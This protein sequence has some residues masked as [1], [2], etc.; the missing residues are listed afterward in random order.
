MN[1]FTSWKQVILREICDDISYG[2]TASASNDIVGPKFLRITD[3]VPELI[4]WDSVPHCE[5]EPQKSDKYLLKAGDIVIARTGATTGYAKRINK[6]VDAVF[7][8]YLVRI[9]VKPEHDNRFV[10]LIVQSD[11]YKRFIHANLG[12][13]AQPQA[14]AQILTSYPIKLPPL[15][16][17]LFPVGNNEKCKVTLKLSENFL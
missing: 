1:I 6:T 15:S 12:G 11:D 17:K 7:A 4:D 8:S 10:G 2:F 16:V 13:A 14:N 5:I 3:I 9:R